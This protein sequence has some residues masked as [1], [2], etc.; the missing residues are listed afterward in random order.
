MSVRRTWMRMC[1]LLVACPMLMARP[2]SAYDILRA[3]QGISATA[4]GTMVRD[5]NGCPAGPP[6]RPL[7]L[8]EAV[9]RA[10]CSNPKTREAWADVKARAAAVGVARAAYLPTVSANWQGVRENS[11]VD[12]EN[13]PSLG[14]AYTAT[15]HSEGVSL[16]WVLFDFG[17]RAAARR[18]ANDLLEAARATQD[19]T[20]QEVFASTAKDYYAAQA[21]TGALEAAQDVE[22]MTRTSMIVAQARVDHGIAPIS[23]ALQAQIQHEQAIMNLTRAQGD[24]QQALGAVA[25]DMDMAPDVP[26]EVPAVTEGSTPSAK[27]FGETIEQLIEAVRTTHPSV[28]AAQAEYDAAL[29]KIT[30]TRAQGLPSVSLVAKYSRDNQP[31]SLGL[32]LPT[33][34]ATGHESYIGVQL[35]IPLFEGFGR[36]Y[37]INQARAEAERQ[38]DVL[39]DTRRQVALDVWNSYHALTT[40]TRNVTNSARLLSISQRAFEAAQQRYVHGVCDVLELMNTQAALANAKQRRVQALADWDNARVDLASKLGRLDV[41]D[42]QQNGN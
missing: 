17:N 31:E 9:E 30:Q 4:A 3:E 16:N 24:V 15:V 38:Q 1:C 23:D 2:A 6:G 27:T 39:D 19:A 25:S 42:L 5:I 7:Q 40:A 22:R 11:V 26:L 37:Q 28:R 12:I 18:S 21:A 13:H 41:T 35:S 33:Y 14:S 36:H 8:F 10:L 32:G 20:L 34:P 29:E